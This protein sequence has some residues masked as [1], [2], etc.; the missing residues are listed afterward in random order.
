MKHLPSADLLCDAL[1]N[2]RNISVGCRVSISWQ[3]SWT[4]SVSSVLKILRAPVALHV[5]VIRSHD[6]AEKGAHGK[7]SFIFQMITVLLWIHRW[8]S[9]M[10]IRLI[11]IRMN[12]LH[13]V[14]RNLW[15]PYWFTRWMVRLIFLSM[16]RIRCPNSVFITF[17]IVLER[18][19]TNFTDK[20]QTH[21]NGLTCDSWGWLDAIWI[22]AG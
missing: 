4:M 12:W 16:I 11:R 2:S 8:P 13:A 22:S 3:I 17:T 9:L 6:E 21:I 5:L 19:I 1:V 14:R 20:S 7:M 15:C 18:N 10:R